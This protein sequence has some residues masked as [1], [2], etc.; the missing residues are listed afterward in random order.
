MIKWAIVAVLVAGSVGFIWTAP[1]K[2]EVDSVRQKI[3]A[4]AGVIDRSTGGDC[5]AV[6]DVAADNVRAA[7][8][9]IN[10]RAPGDAD[11]R[12]AAKRQADQIGA[13]IARLPRTGAGW[14]E[15][16]RE[17]RRAAG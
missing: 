7:V 6:G 15:L 13:C 2:D 12:S 1:W 4:A 11:A 3:A 8:R 14:R 10:D 9:Q 5:A 16:E 17:L